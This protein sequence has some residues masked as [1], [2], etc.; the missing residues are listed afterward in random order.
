LDLAVRLLRGSG[1]DF[2]SGYLFHQKSVLER[3]KSG[4]PYILSTYYFPSE[5]AA[6]FDVEFLYIERTVGLYV[7]SNMAVGEDT[8]ELPKWI[9]S[10]QKAFFE[11]I[12]EGVL[13]LP[14]AMIAIRYP[15]MDAVKLCEH[16]HKTFHV[17]IHYIAV[18][19]LER[20][21]M[22]I[23]SKLD[24]WFLRKQTTYETI[25]L[26]NQA[27]RLKRKVDR[28]RMQ[29]PGIIK[30]DDCLKI[31][32]LENDFGKPIAVSVLGQLLECIEKRT[33]E[34]Q[35]SW[36]VSVFWMGLI[37]LYQNSIL[38]EME[39][40]YPCKF[41][42]E[43]LWLFGANEL[44]EYAFIDEMAKKIRESLFFDTNERINRLIKWIKDFDTNVVVNF[45]QKNCSFLPPQIKQINRRF[46]NEGIKVY[47]L[48]ADV[49]YGGFQKERLIHI[50]EDLV[51][52][53]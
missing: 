1:R 50:I 19:T 21:L 12:K 52:P 6:I 43:E 37:P 15:C 16:L 40:R 26:S 23:Y 5:I 46:E 20:D 32:T 2:L 53:I 27:R 18:D 11:M 42:F 9:C 39:G 47:H 10:Y 49:V 36:K 34:Y 29:Y 4:K 13:P 35:T 8:G 51:S 17:P 41:V 33:E 31:F 7:G 44:S 38:T 45:S 14:Y 25:C 22:K 3:I 48:G 28:Y 30:S 24:K